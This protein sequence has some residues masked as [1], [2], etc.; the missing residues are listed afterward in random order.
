MTSSPSVPSLTYNAKDQTS[1]VGATSFTYAGQNQFERA[2]AG[3]VVW[4][5]WP[6]DEP[7][8]RARV[9]EGLP[10]PGLQPWS[11]EDRRRQRF[12]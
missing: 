11:A 12:R 4:S 1:A 7:G 10:C 2:G 5:E 8:H 9:F 3:S 6:N